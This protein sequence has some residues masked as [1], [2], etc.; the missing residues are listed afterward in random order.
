MNMFG[1]PKYTINKAPYTGQAGVACRSDRSKPG[2]RKSSKQT[3]L[4]TKATQ[5]NK[6]LTKMFTRGKSHKAF[7]PV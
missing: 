2:N 6:E 5:D 7:A 4:E 1:V 3:K